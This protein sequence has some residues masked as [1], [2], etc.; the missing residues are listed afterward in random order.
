M[1]WHDV[2]LWGW[3]MMS[4]GMLVFYGLI[5]WGIALLLRWRGT[6]RALAGSPAARSTRG[7]TERRVQALRSRGHRHREPIS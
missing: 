7:G 6:P 4:V 2:S 1:Y 3:L 5:V